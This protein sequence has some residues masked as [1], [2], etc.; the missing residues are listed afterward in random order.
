MLEAKQ[1]ML[2]TQLAATHVHWHPNAKGDIGESNWHAVLDGRHGRN[3]FLPSRYAVSHAYIIDS[4]GACSD[5]IDLVVHDAHFCP[6]L[7]EQDG[8]RY[9]PAESVY[10]VFEVK[11][12]LS[13]EYVLYAADKVASVR[14]LVRTS[15][16]IVDVGKRKAPRQAFPILG[17]ILTT[18]TGWADP[19]GAAFTRALSDANKLGRLDLGIC[20]EAGA[21]DVSYTDDDLDLKT[22]GADDGLIYFLTRLFSRLQRMG[23]VTAIDLDRYLAQLT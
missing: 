16:E 11:P 4:S 15:V 10:A 5:E 3:G 1:Q 9:I 22:T 20:A 2:R 13:R 19:F 18:R 14:A 21:F 23:T 17:G 7:F 8:H 12:E 6:L